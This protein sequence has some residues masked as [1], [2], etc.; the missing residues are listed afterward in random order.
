LYL[1]VGNSGDN[2]LDSAFL[3]LSQITLQAKHDITLASGT[4]WSL[5]DSTGTGT[6]QLLLEAGNNIIFQNGSAIVDANNWSVSL[7]AGVDFTSPTLKVI[8]VPPGN[9][10]PSINH[11]IYLDGGDGVGGSIQTASGS[12]NLSAGNGIQIGSGTVSS[13]GGNITWQSGGDI[14]FGDGSSI[15]DGNN[16]VVTLDAG[17]D[18]ANNTVQVGVGSIY[19]NGGPNGDGVGGY[20]QTEAGDINLVAGQDITVGAGYVITTGGGSISAHALAGSIDTGSDAQGYVF[21]NS[22][23]SLNAAYNLSGGLGGISTMAGG[24]VTLIAGGDVTSVLPGSDQSYYYDLNPVSVSGNGY[25]T[26]GSGAY[27]SQPGNVT[28]V[29]G[30]NVTGH[31]LAANGYG[32]IY[33]GAQMDANGNPIVAKDAGNNLITEKDDSGNPVK[34]ASGN[35]IYVY[36]L[37]PAS[38]GSAGTD[39]ASG[40]LALSLISGGWNVAAAQNI[41][42]QEVS[43]PNGVFNDANS[44]K[45]Y[46]NYAPGDYVDLSAGNLVQLGASA[47]QLPRLSYGN[48][49]N[50][51]N[52]VPIIYPS[53]LNIVAGTGGVILG[54]SGSGSPSSLILFPSPQGSLTIDTSGS[55]VSKLG[56]VS[57]PRLFNLIVSDAGHNQYTTTANFGAGDHAASPVHANALTPIYLN[58]GGD[59]DYLDL[60]VPEAAQ[61]TIGGN[62]NN[63]GF[64]GMNLSLDPSFQD[65]I[66][67]AD[68]SARAVTVDPSLT[69]INVSGDI[70]N[71]S[72][73]TSVD[74]S[75]YPYAQP[76]NAPGYIVGGG[77]QFDITAQTIDLGTSGG[78]QSAGVAAYT[79][80]GSYPLRNL[81]G[82]GGVFDHGADITVTTTGNHSAGETASGDL[83]GDLDMYSSSIASLDGGNISINAGGD[84]NAGSSV[85]TVNTS[86]ATGIYSTSQGDISVIASG[87]VNVNGSRITTY[88]GGN[89]TVESLN[90]SVNAGTGASQPVGVTGYYEDPVTHAVDF[91]SPQIPFSGILALTFPADPSYPE[92]PPTLGNILIEAPNGN[93]TA[94]AAGILQIPLNNLNYPDAATTVLAGYE[95]RDSLGNPVTAAD[96]ADGTPVLVSADR[97]INVSGSGII[98]GNANLDASGN[99]AGLI[100]ARDN[101]NINAQQNINVTA[102]GIGNV[103]VSSSGG[104][105]SGTLIG[106]NGVSASGS[107]VDASLISANV[108]GTTSGQSGLGQ[109][110]AANGTSQG[111]A[112][113]ESTQAAATSDNSNDDQKKKGKQIALAQKVSRVTVILPPKNVSETQTKTPGT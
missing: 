25:L 84:V 97:D 41:S 8:P 15:S 34:D 78:I 2:Y 29:A 4:T 18:F 32:A 90:G 55:L 106:V 82:N 105:I 13:S 112:N 21:A 81:F 91:T 96:M 104:T 1:N 108:S 71:Q 98:A 83:I 79:I 40:G 107:S 110:T 63:C 56:S 31:Y 14:L 80:R 3:G 33:A 70:F 100:F 69:S 6:G 43:N 19:L 48:P 86:G 30:G 62:M 54:V 58:I 72:G 85:F 61:I 92:P 66:F 76:D 95:L 102:F 57:A 10:D 39:L 20:I 9:T 65:Q 36:A 26:A 35:D 68:G 99:I 42:L 16:G 53:I 109:G 73:F 111:L 103:S 113:N 51:V 89:V 47:K 46:F 94:D 59:M 50:D 101:I 93:I 38:T 49:Q 67:E 27:G 24:D 64:Q 17:Y 52:N 5:S 7:F 28:I 88:D 74:L 22:A 12:I 37:N 75:A 87:D 77:G 23:S 60:T 44:Y 45:H 11:S